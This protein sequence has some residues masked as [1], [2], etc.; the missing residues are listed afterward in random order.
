MRFN[1]QW[2]FIRI[3]NFIIPL[4]CFYIFTLLMTCQMSYI[5]RPIL[6][7]PIV[8]RTVRKWFFNFWIDLKKVSFTLPDPLF[9]ILQSSF[10][11]VHQWL[12]RFHRRTNYQANLLI[13]FAS[14]N[15]YVWAHKQK[16]VLI[17]RK[18]VKIM[19]S[20]NIMQ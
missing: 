10:W 16:I 20:L 12:H 17:S 4:F 9:E 7:E 5:V 14:K 19:Q 18:S 13:C 3:M 6:S 1:F 11:R 2:D 8:V 15:R